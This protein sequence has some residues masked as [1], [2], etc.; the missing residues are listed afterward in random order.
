M[1]WKQGLMAVTASSRVPVPARGSVVAADE[2]GRIVLW[3]A[4]EHDHSTEACLWATFARAI[5]SADTDVTVDLS[6]VEF[7]DAGTVGVILR[8]RAL[9]RRRS[10]SLV[11]RAPSRRAW[12]VIRLCGL[13]DLV[14]AG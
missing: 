2:D 5:A 6:D 7:M 4:G 14:R 12:R 8:A 10:R 1:R 11:L 3:L 9:L 13:A